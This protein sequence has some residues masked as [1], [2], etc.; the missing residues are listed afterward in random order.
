M[1]INL[2]EDV[3][4]LRNK[5]A[6]RREVIDSSGGD[7]SVH[8]LATSLASLYSDLQE[9]MGRHRVNDSRLLDVARTQLQEQNDRIEYIKKYLGAQRE[10][11]TDLS[12]QARLLTGKLHN[13]RGISKSF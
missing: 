7:T 13:V 6:N 1:L 9:K 8:D 11:L 4:R 5:V 10:K 12:T 3:T 2:L